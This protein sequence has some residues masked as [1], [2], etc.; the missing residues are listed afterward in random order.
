MRREKLYPRGRDCTREPVYPF[1]LLWA[2]QDQVRSGRVEAIEVIACKLEARVTSLIT[3]VEMALVFT[4]M[5]MMM[6]GV[7]C[8]DD[9]SVVVWESGLM[10]GVV[11]EN[12][13]GAG[14]R[15]CGLVVVDG[16]GGWHSAWAVI[17]MV[18]NVILVVVNEIQHS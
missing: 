14:G 16:G 6:A 9:T 4:S 3:M 12:V 15:Q 8:G 18:E 1:I 10:A 5:G 13:V 7:V 11:V 17:V 2:L